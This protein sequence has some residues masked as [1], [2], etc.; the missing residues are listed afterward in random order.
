MKDNILEYL[1]QDC[2]ERF[3]IINTTP[4]KAKFCPRCSNSHIEEYKYL[5]EE[6]GPPQWEFLCQHC[7]THFT[8]DS[9]EGPD[10]VKALKCP[11]C[12]SNELKWI[13]FKAN[14]CATGG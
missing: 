9:P 6:P 13:A 3:S 14:Q 11:I 4:G 10:E 5:M 8:V 2:A 12:C 7:G 1:C